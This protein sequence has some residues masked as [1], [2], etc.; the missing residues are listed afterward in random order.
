MLHQSLA[1][2]TR[3]AYFRIRENGDGD[4]Q[5][6]TVYVLD[7]I[8]AASN[9]TAFELDAMVTVVRSSVRVAA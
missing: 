9:N 7:N 4:C 3:D 6:D 2:I 5:A 8:V 1:R